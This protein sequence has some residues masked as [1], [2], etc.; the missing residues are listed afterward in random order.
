MAHQLTE[1]KGAVHLMQLRFQ[2]V[3]Y[4]QLPRLLGGESL[5]MNAMQLLETTQRAFDRLASSSLRRIDGG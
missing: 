5:T 3:K 4:E 2:W 1:E